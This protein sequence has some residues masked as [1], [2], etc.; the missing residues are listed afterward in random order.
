[1]AHSGLFRIFGFSAL[2]FPLFFL[3]A[4]L[5]TQFPNPAEPLHVYPSLASLPRSNRVWSI[6]D[7]SYYPGGEYVTFPNGRVRDAVEPPVLSRV[8]Q[9]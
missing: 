8:D 7:E 5:L 9:T 4:Y 6:Y 3:A 2:I 1:M